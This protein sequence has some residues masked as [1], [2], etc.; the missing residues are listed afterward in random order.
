[1]PPKSA[2]QKTEQEV[3]VPGTETALDLS[4]LSAHIA[5][6]LAAGLSEASD[7]RERYG[8]TD[9]QWAV[10]SKNKVFRAML[11]EAIEKVRGD[12]NAGR[13][14]TMKSEIALEDSIPE[15]YEM[16]RSADVPAAARVESI[17]TLAQLAG[18]N[19]KGEGAAAA[20]GGAGF[21][22][23][24]QIVAGSEQHTV[25]VE[26]TPAIEHAA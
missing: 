13:R 4:S 22:I 7:V 26:G 21:A 8:I 18:R 15:L 9:E 24:I 11:K 16:A 19:M 17:K 1:M 12:M 25:A 20:P 6:E 23:N 3:T 2:S 5:M 10:L 14:I